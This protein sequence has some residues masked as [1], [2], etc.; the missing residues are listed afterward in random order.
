MNKCTILLF[1][2]IVALLIVATFPVNSTTPVVSDNRPVAVPRGSTIALTS[3]VNSYQS[4]D[5]TT[6][7]KYDDFYITVGSTP[8]SI[9]AVLDS[10][11]T[12]DFDLYY[13][14]GTTATSSAYDMNAYTSSADE[15]ITLSSTYLKTGTHYF[16]V[17]RYGGTGTDYYYFK[18]TVAG[19]AADTTAPTVSVT[20]PTAGATVSGTTTISAT[21]SDNVGVASVA[22]YVDSALVSTDTS[23]PYSYSWATTSYSNGAHSIYAIAKDAAGNSKTSTTVSVTVSNTVTDDGGLLTAGVTANG[24][25][26]TTDGA[27]MWYIDVPSNTVSMQVV[28]ECGSADFDTYG[29]YNAQPTTSTYDW[30][31][32][33]SGGED[34]TVTSPTAGRHYIMVDYY[35]GSGAYTLKVTLTSG[36]STDTT[37]PT[38]SV[39]APT[40]G[41]TVSGST[42]I[43]ASASDN[44]GVTSV[45]FYIG[46]TLLATDT[47]SPYSC[48][49][50]TTSYTNGAYS[51]S[52]K[53]KDAAGNV[54]TSS[55]VSV[56]VSNTVVDDGGALTA[57][58]TAN[59]NMDTTDGSDMWYIDVPSGTTSM[60][61]VLE[62][63]SS[64]FDDYGKFN[65][66]PTTSTYDWRG[67]TS[68]GEE[69]TVTSPS[70][71]RHYIMVQFYS[72]SGAY[73]LKV[74][75]TSGGGGG[76]GG[77]WGTGGKYA[78]IVGI[79]DYTSI[80]DLSF[81]DEDAYDWYTFMVSKGYECHVYY[82]QSYTSN[83]FTS[84]PS[85]TGAGVSGKVTTATES[86]VRAAIQALAAYAVSGNSVAFITSGHG[87]GDGAGSSYLC[88]LDCSGSTGC[89]Y[90]TELKA[91]FNAFASGVKIFFFVDHCYSGGL[92][93]E[94]LTIADVANL[95][96]TTTC[97]ANGYG[98]DDPDHSNGAWTYYFLEN[99]LVSH[100]TSSM[101]AVFDAV[102]PSYP[103]TGGD[104][105]MEFDGATGTAFY[106]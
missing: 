70:T 81:C 48:S 43:S 72:G 79:S 64:D 2:G 54:G 61:V 95:Y 44:V 62:C 87:S 22:F 29:K 26:D 17:Q 57:G 101:E 78:V 3:G 14:Y 106:L 76:G 51:I 105:A 9:V 59:G 41:A 84:I 10:V 68:G 99:Y 50:A 45:E 28:M 18:V 49:W 74:T 65:A 7:G 53:A 31:G 100:A 4:L 39:T 83:K 92:G 66:Q 86:N 27:D 46:T 52:A 37:A 88:M 58:V 73:T 80:N 32:Y 67:Y 33:T 21:A 104:A 15:T 90:D 42:T 63:G 8:T 60:Y 82:D 40:A 38:V 12:D 6:T 34:N 69:N 97:T 93:P 20:A 102:S 98:Y 56:T 89:Y 91:D 25:M 94:M 77:A 23:S 103:H 24:N 35:S 36:G 30:R 13:K 75:L 19:G 1:S 5:T 71:G 47:S 55:S 96:M 11:G 16:R 85:S